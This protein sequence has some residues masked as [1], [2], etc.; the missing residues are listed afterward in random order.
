MTISVFLVDDHAV[1]RDG[2]REL[3]QLERDIRVVGDAGNGREAVRE[4]TRLH[5][6]VA[7]MDIEMQ[8]LDGIE[9]TRQVKE[10]CPSTEVVILSLSCSTPY[11]QR[12]TRAG[13]R[14]Y[15]LKES[16]G[17]AVVRA[18][19]DV[20]A[21]QLHLCRE[22]QEALVE[23]VHDGSTGLEPTDPLAVLSKR[24]REVFYAVLEG[25]PNVKIA[26][27]L[28][29]S[30][31]TVETYRSRMKAKLGCSNDVELVRWAYDH[32]ILRPGSEK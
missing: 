23:A 21:G 31:K 3:L 27:D 25:K 6:D 16:A 8:G 7:V 19:R 10:I 13:A 32:E 5:P 26:E 11:V 2:L 24:E 9:A 20:Y 14:G 29:L 4:I 12:A 1:L 17:G 28:C 22:A 15:V 18:V 30:I